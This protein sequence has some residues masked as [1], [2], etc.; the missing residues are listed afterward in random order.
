MKTILLS[1]VWLAV[2]CGAA[3]LAIARRETLG[4]SAYIIIG[5]AIVML[6]LFAVDRLPR[7]LENK[8]P[9]ELI[10]NLFTG[11]LILFAIL[12]LGVSLLKGYRNLGIIGSGILALFL[13]VFLRIFA[14]Y[15]RDFWKKSRRHDGKDVS[16]PTD[17]GNSDT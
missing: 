2:V 11:L 17:E 3:A 13:I 10:G 8:L 12:I 9:T 14:D 15:V 1:I 6:V 5:G 4:I 16:R 7:G